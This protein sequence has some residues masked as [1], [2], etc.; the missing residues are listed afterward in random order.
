MGDG[1]D[2]EV[3]DPSCGNRRVVRQQGDRGARLAVLPF[4]LHRVAGIFQEGAATGQGLGAQRN[5]Q[6]FHPSAQLPEGGEQFGFLRLRPRVPKIFAEPDEIK[7]AGR[8]LD[9]VHEG[10]RLGFDV[11]R[12]ALASQEQAGDQTLNPV[13]QN[14]VG[15]VD[16]DASFFPQ[17]GDE[18]RVGA[19]RQEQRCDAAGI[20]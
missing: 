7:S 10:H 9:G 20:E 6:V 12:A 8:Q 11:D 1:R 18:E 3:E 16:R 19:A 13:A 2:F 15:F 14:R 17:P 5:G 4:V